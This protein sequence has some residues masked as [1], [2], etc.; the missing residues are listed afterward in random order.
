MKKILLIVLGFLLLL[1]TTRVFG[2]SLDDLNDEVY[3]PDNLPGGR[4]GDAAVET[5]IND[6]IN[7]AIN[8]ILYTAGGIAVLMLIIGGIVAI[9]S[10][11][12]QER[13]ERAVKIVKFALIGL[14]VVIL[15]FAVV[16]N[17]IDFIFR[18]TT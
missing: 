3:R 14:F 12:N 16:T 6:V 13:K 1:P 2:I 8:L 18:A 11:G 4:L 15:A 10:L 5:K 7:F 17:V 9:S